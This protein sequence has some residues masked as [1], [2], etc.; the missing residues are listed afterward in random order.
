MTHMPL[1]SEGVQVSKSPRDGFVG[2]VRLVLFQQSAARPGVV[3]FG[4]G[5]L[6]VCFLERIKCDY[7]AIYL[8]QGVVQVSF[9]ICGC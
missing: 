5:V 7:D 6:Q 8:G 1:P 4:N 9:R 2:Q 3:G